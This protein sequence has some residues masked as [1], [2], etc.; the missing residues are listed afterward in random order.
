MIL[1]ILKKLLTLL[2]VAGAVALTGCATPATKEAM[3][4][5]NITP[6]NKHPYSV[7][8]KASGGTETGAMDSSNVSNADFKAA[9]ESSIVQSG[10]FKQVVQGDGGDY[11]LTVNIVQ[12]SK[13]TIGF[14]FTVNMEA[15]WSLTKVSDKS[16]VM[17]KVIRS[18][19]TAT[20]GDAFAGVTR[21]RMAVEGAAKKN[22]ELGLQ[23]VSKLE[24]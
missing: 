18:S 5:G 9:I 22:I 4:A 7:S 17:R 24:L 2:L 12:L 15:A 6:V 14:N 10:L 16:V 1:R 20:M 19:H 23:E 8:V 11:E 13:P 21:L 3:T